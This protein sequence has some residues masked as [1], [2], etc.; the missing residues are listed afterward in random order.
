[1]D[2]GLRGYKMGC[3]SGLKGGNLLSA[4]SFV[5]ALVVLLTVLLVTAVDLGL[6]S[7]LAIVV[8]I[9]LG[10][11]VFTLLLFARILGRL[12]HGGLHRMIE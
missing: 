4:R 11:L 2:P 8:G 6:F 10:L 12:G 1:M 7:A 5:C 3:I 9:L